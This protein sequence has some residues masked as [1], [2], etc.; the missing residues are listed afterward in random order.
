MIKVTIETS[1]STGMSEVK[2]C[3]GFNNEEDV[4]SV[5]ECVEQAMYACGYRF[6]GNLEFVE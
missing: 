6:K 1:N 3:E 4:Q 2:D 5:L